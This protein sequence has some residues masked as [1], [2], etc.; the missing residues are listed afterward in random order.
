MVCLVGIVLAFAVP[1]WQQHQM[2]VQRRQA[3]LQLGEIALQQ[4]LW[5]MQ[6]GTYFSNLLQAN[7]VIHSNHYD[8]QVELPSATWTESIGQAFLLRAKAKGGQKQDLHCATLVLRYDGA[9]HGVGEGQVVNE[10]Q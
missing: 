5:K 4:E 9:R 10:C 2:V 7:I 1:S 6:H 3:W 8:Y